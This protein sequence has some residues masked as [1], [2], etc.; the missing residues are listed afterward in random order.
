MEDRFVYKNKLGITALK[1]SVN[2]LVL[3]KHS[4]EE[5]SLAVTLKGEQKY[6]LEGFS[7][8]SCKNGITLFNPEQIH[9]SKSGSCDYVLLL[10]KPQLVL[11]GL[12]QKNIIK[13]DSPIIYNDK[14]KQD[15]L[16]LSNAILTQKDELFCSELFLNV[17]DNFSK[18]DFIFNSKKEKDFIEK[19]KEMI[20][21]EIENILNIEQ[22]SN[23]FNISKFQFIRKFK[24]N[25]G[26]TP[27]Q[28]FLNT[29]LN[30]ARKYLDSKKD[31]YGAIVEFGFSDLSHF[32]RHFKR[33]YGITPFEYISSIDR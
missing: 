7:L 22:I 19:S 3:K 15:I 33:V 12:E 32:N 21:Y 14:L 27:Y 13:F 18:K 26:F 20:Y 11:E 23:E 17:V 16:N 2:K 31:L 24:A 1:A 6:L 8:T 28:Y 5:Y 4:H 25:T 29:K 30:H 10:I 9:E